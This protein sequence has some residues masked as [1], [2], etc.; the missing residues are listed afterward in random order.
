M[1]S[2]MVGMKR[3]KAPVKT[4]QRQLSLTVIRTTCW[5]KTSS[6]PSRT[7]MLLTPWFCLHSST[8]LPQWARVF[9]ERIAGMV[10]ST[11][12]HHLL[13]GGNAYLKKLSRSKLAWKNRRVSKTK[14]FKC[15]QARKRKK[16]NRPAKKETLQIKAKSLNSTN[17]SSC[18]NPR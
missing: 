16:G 14:S 2:A 6:P 18:M 5:T 10:V 11:M 17:M 13:R 12:K 15:R 4:H 9:R 1:T 8:S 3:I 7:K